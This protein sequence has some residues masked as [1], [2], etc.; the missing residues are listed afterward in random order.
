MKDVNLGE[1]TS[2]LDH[3]YLG[4]IQ[5]ECQT[6]KDIVDDFKNMFES[7]ISAETMENYMFPGIRMRIFL[8]G[9]MTRK[10]T[11]R[12][13]WKDIAN[14]QKKRLN[15]F[16]KSQLHVLTSTTSKKKKWDLSENCQKYAHKLFWNAC[17]WPA[18]VDLIFHGL[19]TNFFMLSLMD[20]SLW[21]KLNTFDLIHSSHIWIQKNCHVGN[22]AQECR[23][24]L[25]QDSD[26][27]GDPEDSKSKSGWTL[28]HI[29]K[30]H[31]RANR[32]AVQETDFSFTQFN[33]IWNHCFGCKFTH[34]WKSSSWSL[35]FG[36]KK[37]FILL[38]T[39]WT[40]PRIKYEETRRVI[41]HQTST[42]KTKPRFQPSKTTLMWAMLKFGAMLHIFWGQR[43]RSPTMRHVS[44]TH[45]VALD[46]LFD[47]INLD[48]KI[49]TKYVDTKHQFADI[50]T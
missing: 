39:N 22:T 32:L 4:C 18:L 42:P 45:R 17:I 37:C 43:S 19:W 2:F 20:Q 23:L 47:R 28:A 41:P 5:R 26:F 34:G 16:I 48:P 3:V 12:N 1:P 8:L 10:V 13:V 14:L 36:H 27:A 6:N 35:G 25:F 11:R 7:R 29:R 46:W 50:L 21:Q 38:R 24:G 9:P 44:R 40:K 49:Q 15:N 30:S 33:G 31:V